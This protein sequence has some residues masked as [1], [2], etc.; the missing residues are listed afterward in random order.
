[1]LVPAIRAVGDAA[2]M[3]GFLVGLREARRERLPPR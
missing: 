2:K 1:M 3:L